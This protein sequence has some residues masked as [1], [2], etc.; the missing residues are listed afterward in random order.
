MKRALPLLVF[1]AAGAAVLLLL[2]ARTDRGPF[3]RTP[4]GSEAVAW[5]AAVQASRPAGTAVPLPAGTLSPI[6]PELLKNLVSTDPEAVSRARRILALGLL[7][8]FAAL[9]LIL[10]WRRAGPWPA[11]IAGVASLAAGPLVLSAGSLS[12]AVPAAAV[13]L[14]GLV[15]LDLGRSRVLAWIAGGILIALAGRLDPVLSWVLFILLLAG[16]LVRPGV[17][18][19]TRFLRPAA[20]AGGWLAALV[21]TAS[22]MDSLPLFPRISGIEMARGNRPAASGVDP[23]RA[24]ADSLRWW[25]PVDYLREASRQENRRLTVPEAES[26]WAARV[27]AEAFSQPV[28]G[29]RRTGVKTL[30]SLEGDPLPREVS[31]AFLRTWTEGWGLPVVLW[32][33]RI[34]IPLGLWGLLLAWKRTGWLLGAAALSGVGAAWLTYATPDTRILTVCAALAGLGLWVER[35]THGSSR[36]RAAGLAGGVLAVGVLG[37][38]PPAV[39]TPGLGISGEDHY[40]LGLVYEQEKRGSAAIR[41]YERSLRLEPGNPYPHLAIA[42]MLAADNVNQEA[43]LE[44]E[45]LRARDPGFVPGLLGLSRLYQAEQEWRKATTIYGDLVQ[46]EPWNP[47]HW[48]NLGTMYVQLGLYDQAARALQEALRIAPNYE[49]ARGNLASLQARGLV[50]GTPAGA[51]SVRIA[52]EQ[53][54]NHIRMGQN[55]E[56]EAALEEAYGKFGK[57]KPEFRFVEGTLRL[58]TGE[59]ERA[60][61]I[62]EDLR[63]SMGDNVILL[64]NLA[65]AYRQTGNRQKAIEVYE[66]ALRLAPANERVRV[67]LQELRAEQDSIAAGR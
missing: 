15:I 1:L 58:V 12:P 50:A 43:I 39:G 13:L 31:A 4:L 29:I 64:N 8:V 27:P 36:V 52:Q 35:M 41:E 6:Y 17:Q 55:D 53:I 38:L 24:D 51:D 2:V 61:R 23:R 32:A 3:E 18:G 49:T 57:D 54:L 14:L 33:G 25:G 16:I 59:S 42:R 60:V 30:A 66:E 65:A 21:L 7:P 34:L 47:E 44:L 20:L 37:L 63:E 56:A 28:R 5:T 22:A 9:V 67:S 19:K 40:Q 26:W 46:A 62:F 11:V 45:Q 48:N 10:V